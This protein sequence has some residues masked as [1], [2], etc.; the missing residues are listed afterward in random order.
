MNP[1]S[2]K[3]PQDSPVGRGMAA[4]TQTPANAHLGQDKPGLFDQQ[5]SVGKQFTPEGAIGGTAQ[6]IGGPLDKEGMVGKQFTAGGSIGGTVQ[7]MMGGMSKK[8]N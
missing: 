8:S 7:D 4:A 5:G 6:K 1:I 2:P 3:Q